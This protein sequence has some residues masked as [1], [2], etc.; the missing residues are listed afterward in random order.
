LCVFIFLSMLAFVEHWKTRELTTVTNRFQNYVN[1]IW[2]SSRSSDLFKNTDKIEKYD[3]ISR[4]L[5]DG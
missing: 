4:Y 5:S 2:H 3:R 1:L